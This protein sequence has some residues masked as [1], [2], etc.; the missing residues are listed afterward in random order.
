[1]NFVSIYNASKEQ[2]SLTRVRRDCPEPHFFPEP[3]PDHC[4]DGTGSERVSLLKSGIETTESRGNILL[5]SRSIWVL[6]VE[7]G[8]GTKIPSEYFAGT[9]IGTGFSRVRDGRDRDEKTTVPP[10]PISHN[11]KLVLR[12]LS[13]TVCSCLQGEK[14][15]NK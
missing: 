12:I 1:M 10:D 5:G 8:N 6:S 15:K 7:D 2:Q 11:K 14:K 3:D 9:G 4:S 13:I